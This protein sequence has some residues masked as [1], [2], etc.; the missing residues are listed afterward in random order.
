MTV[1]VVAPVLSG[2]CSVHVAN[3]ICRDGREELL[4]AMDARDARS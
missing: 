1:L 3:R 2:L 4:Q